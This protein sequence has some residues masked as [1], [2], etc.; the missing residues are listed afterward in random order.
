MNV[1]DEGND[2]RFRAA[3]FV[4]YTLLSLIVMSSLS[5]IIYI[6]SK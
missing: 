3:L 1:K 2:E 4:P 6:S 5:A